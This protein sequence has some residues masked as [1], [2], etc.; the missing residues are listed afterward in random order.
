MSRQDQARARQEFTARI[1]AIST[2]DFIRRYVI[3]ESRAGGVRPEEV[4]VATIQNDG[5]GP[6]TVAY[7][8]AGTAKL[9][10]KLYRDPSGVHAWE[11][12]RR[13]WQRGFHADGR[14]QV[15]QPLCFLGQYN[16]VLMRAAGGTSLASSLDFDETDGRAV[17]GTREAARWLARLHSSP[18]RIGEVDQPWYIFSKLAARLSKAAAAHAEEVKRLTGMLDRLEELADG[19]PQDAV[20]VHGQFRPIHVFLTDQ[21]V[22]VI[23]LDR[24][25]VAEPAWDLAEFLHRLRSSIFRSGGALGRADVLSRAFL[26]E[27]ATRRPTDVRRLPFYHA[28]HI[29]VSLC[30]HMK[31]SSRDDPEWEPGANFYLDEW[32]RALAESDWARA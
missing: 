14:Y 23:D 28:F 1:A 27:Y 7:R 21:T 31:R 30:R 16:L 9:F 8:I 19:G 15:P 5:T 2:S 26:E 6:A 3:P 25:R 32:E 11:V 22:T 29:L 20:Q 18:I 10:A 13:L 17:D 4:E 12:L 24:S